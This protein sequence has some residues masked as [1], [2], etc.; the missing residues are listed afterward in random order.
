MN[1]ESENIMEKREKLIEVERKFLV[2][3]VCKRE[4]WEK[5]FI[6]YQWY[7]TMKPEVSVKFKIIFD[8]IR[9]RRVVAR[10]TKMKRD[11]YTW[12]KE[13]EYLAI[14]DEDIKKYIGTGFVAKRRAIAGKIFLDRFIRSNR[15][16]EYL[17]E[18]EDDVRQEA[19]NK[20]G[21]QIGQEVSGKA[22]YLNGNMC[23][24]FE[25]KDYDE[26]CILLAM[27]PGW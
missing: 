6:I 21:I 12:D 22:E 25:E 2:E 1:K 24:P 11:D 4:N 16:C 23:V 27:I 17:L 13:V 5:E 26:L 8:L 3:S 19:L 18:I 10:I 20:L 9:V 14:E 15:I 7:E